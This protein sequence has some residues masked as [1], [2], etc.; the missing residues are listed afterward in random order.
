MTPGPV[1]HESA[2]PARPHKTGSGSAG[3]QHLRPGV[4]VSR[5]GSSFK[6]SGG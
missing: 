1:T 4:L 3:H 5:A 6:K 2:E